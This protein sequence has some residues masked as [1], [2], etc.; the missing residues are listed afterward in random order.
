M[1][2][3]I[4]KKTTIWDFPEGLCYLFAELRT[5][6][7]IDELSLFGHDICELMTRVGNS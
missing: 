2:V 7:A 3:C 4:S 6:D 1:R 5:E